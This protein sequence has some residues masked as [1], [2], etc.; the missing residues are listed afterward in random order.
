VNLHNNK[1]NCNNKRVSFTSFSF[2]TS[3]QEMHY[4]QCINCS[5]GL[6]YYYSISKPFPCCLQTILMYFSIRISW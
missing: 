1:I 5:F 3:L 6:L 4:C 2:I